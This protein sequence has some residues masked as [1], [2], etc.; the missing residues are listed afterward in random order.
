MSEAEAEITPKQPPIPEVVDKARKITPF[1]VMR[2]GEDSI[3]SENEVVFSDF[4]PRVV[5][6]DFPDEELTVPKDVSA[7][8]P[9]PSTDLAPA[10]GRTTSVTS[11]PPSVN[12]DAGKLN[13]NATS[14]PPSS[15]PP[16]SG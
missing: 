12:S 16:K 3:D 9:A 10:S 6:A 11:V 8:A 7:P 13:Q 1:R 2:R 15:T 4:S 14:S 5:P